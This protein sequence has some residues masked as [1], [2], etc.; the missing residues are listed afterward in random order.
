VKSIAK[1]RAKHDQAFRDR[2]NI[3]TQLFRED[4]FVAQHS[5]KMNEVIR[6]SYG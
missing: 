3:C 6:D 4:C 1:I 2:Q 5:L